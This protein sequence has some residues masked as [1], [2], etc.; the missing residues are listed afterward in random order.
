MQ[1]LR[2]LTGHGGD[3][4]AVVQLGGQHPLLHVAGEQGKQG[5]N[6]QQ[7]QSKTGIFHRD[8]RHDGQNAARIR[9]HADDAGGKQRL[10]RVHIPGKPGGD[11]AGILVNKGACGQPGQLPG[12]FRAQSVGHFLAEQ[13]EQ[14]FLRGR[15]Q[16][17]QRKTAKV[18]LY[19][20]KRQSAAHGQ[21]ID[22]PCQQ[23]RR[24]QGRAHRRRH[25][26]NRP[27]REKMVGCCHRP[28]GGKHTVFIHESAL[29]SGFRRAGG[30]P[31]RMPSVPRE[32]RRWFC[33]PP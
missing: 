22:H 12:H 28:Y 7:N 32:C 11:L 24:E 31:E 2:H 29:L 9:H 15:K 25:A 8:D 17:L 5:Q 13:H 14:A 16:S 26:E 4:A 23:Q 21:A 6:Q 20:E 10:N 3:G 18:A 33:R 1:R 30:T 27:H 19:R